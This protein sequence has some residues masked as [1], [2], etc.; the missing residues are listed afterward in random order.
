VWQNAAN[1]HGGTVNITKGNEMIEYRKLNTEVHAFVSEFELFD[2]DDTVTVH[3]SWSYW[4]GLDVEMRDESGDL[5]DG[6]KVARR[7]GFADDRALALELIDDVP[8]D[9]DYESLRPL[10]GK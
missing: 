8:S 2:N 10:G 3:V 4:E 5:L 9:H 6:D 7:F 1:R